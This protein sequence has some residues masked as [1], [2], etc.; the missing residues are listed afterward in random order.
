LILCDF[1]QCHIA[2]DTSSI[3]AYKYHSIVKPTKVWKNFRWVAPG[4]SS[5]PKTIPHTLAEQ[6]AEMY[7]NAAA[8]PNF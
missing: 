3:H 2:F 1:G 6:M 5:W 4:S 8:K 7:M